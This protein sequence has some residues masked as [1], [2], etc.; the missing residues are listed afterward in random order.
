MLQ[1]KN[2]DSKKLKSNPIYKHSKKTVQFLD[3]RL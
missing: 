2:P 1:E 3:K